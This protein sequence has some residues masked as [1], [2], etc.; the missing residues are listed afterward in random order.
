MPTECVGKKSKIVYVVYFSFG[1]HFTPYTDSS[2][3][4]KIRLLSTYHHCRY[5]LFCCF[6]EQ[7]E[8]C[9]VH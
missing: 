1:G 4:V 2:E 6:I 5:T 9:F 3:Q 7:H 8:M